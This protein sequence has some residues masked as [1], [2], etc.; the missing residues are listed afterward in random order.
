MIIVYPITELSPDMYMIV[1]TLPLQCLLAA[2]KLLS[3][4]SIKIISEVL[5]I[6]TQ[7]TLSQEFITS[8]GDG[9]QWGY[10]EQNGAIATLFKRIR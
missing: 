6:Q 5:E 7:K 2:A 3:L 1:H 9:I 8:K 10:S 4:D